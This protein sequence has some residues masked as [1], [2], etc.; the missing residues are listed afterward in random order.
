MSEARWADPVAR[1]AEL[2]FR[3]AGRAVANLIS[4][5]I[6]ATFGLGVMADGA[7][8][9]DPSVAPRREQV[10]AHGRVERP[11][12]PELSVDPHFLSRRVLR[13]RDWESLARRVL[14]D[15]SVDGRA[16]VVEDVERD[17]VGRERV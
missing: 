5:G 6:A 2:S 4:F 9:V 11:G 1:F 15:G 14:E 10:R 12:S 8:E 3:S 7:L 16:V 13:Q 17:D